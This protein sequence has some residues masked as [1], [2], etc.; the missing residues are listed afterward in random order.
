MECQARSN[1]RIRIRWNQWKENQRFRPN[2]QV[3]L[4]SRNHPLFEILIYSRKSILNLVIPL[5]DQKFL[6][7]DLA[8]SIDFSHIIFPRFHFLSKYY[9]SYDKTMRFATN[10][11]RRRVSSSRDGT[12]IGDKTRG[13]ISPEILKLTY[14]HI[15]V[16][17]G[18]SDENFAR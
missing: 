15:H 3:P 11:A 4:Y 6:F 9:L 2:D 10:L 13:H 8:R 14:P 7:H 5:N 18:M 17:N 1:G 16:F 12:N